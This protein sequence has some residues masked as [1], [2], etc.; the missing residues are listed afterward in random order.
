[1][2]DAITIRER[3]L[4]IIESAELTISRCESINSSQEFMLSPEK[5]MLFDS[6]VMRLQVIGEQVGKLLKAD[7]S[8]LIY[9]PEINWKD[10]YNMRNFISHEYA[11]VDEEIIYDVIKNELPTLLIAVNDILLKV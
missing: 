1:M 11:N 6:V 7:P 4:Q 2:S 3:L 5:V 8:P 9:H 10:V